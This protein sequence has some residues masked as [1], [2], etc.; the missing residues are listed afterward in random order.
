MP[1]PK[2]ISVVIPNYNGAYLLTETI[3]TVFAALKKLLSPYEVI[4]ADDCSTDDSIALLQKNF[5][6][7]KIMSNSS[8]SGF[9][10]TANAGIR[11][12]Q[13]ELVL[14]LNNDVKLEPGYFVHQLPYFEQADTFGVMGRIVG[15][16]DDIIQDG[17]KYPS[18]H[19][20]KIK[21][22]RNYLLA[23]VDEM[24]NGLYSMYLSGANALLD[25]DK[26]LKLG[27][28]NE[29]FSPFY[30]EDYELS[31][32][33]WRAGWKCYYD[34]RSVCRH[35]T[36]ITIRAKCDKNFIRMIYN[37]N[38]M[39]LHAIH[40]GAGARVLW[41]IQLILEILFQ[42]LLF[43]TYYSRAFILFLKQGP[44]IKRSREKL[45]EMGSGRKLLTIN[46]TVHFIRNSVKDKRLNF[47]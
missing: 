41:M 39:F 24:K 37:R 9:S 17:A 22:S 25:R 35:R 3:P 21:T 33:A 27:G 32:R 16:E 13:Y 4:V 38:K 6:E 19:N 2:G 12:A 36:S 18:F 14:L 26:F 31:L 46:E 29:L 1:A 5:P 20:V 10:V 8:N 45:K 15:W 40:L 11:K 44:R 28:F 23:D 47:F 43:K 34:F 42:S 7:V 30:V